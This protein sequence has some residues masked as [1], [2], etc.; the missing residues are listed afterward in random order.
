MAATLR[1]EAGCARY[2]YKIST[3]TATGGVGVGAVDLAKLFAGTRVLPADKAAAGGAGVLYIE[4]SS[5]AAAGGEPRPAD[6]HAL[7]MSSLCYRGYSE[8]VERA[9]K[10]QR[11][12]DAA[13][14]AAA[15]AH[16]TDAS[17]QQPPP[18]KRFD[19]QVT[20]LVRLAGGASANCKVFRNG[21]VQITGLRSIED[22]PLFIEQLISEARAASAV[23]DKD[24]PNMHVSSYAI[25]LIN[26]DVRLGYE[27][28]REVLFDELRVRCPHLYVSYEP[29]IYPG[30]KFLF[31]WNDA[32]AEQDGACTCK[33]DRPN[34]CSGRGSGSG[35][36]QCK[37]MTVAVF[38]SGCMLV[39]GGSEYAHIDAAYAYTLRLLRE[40]EPCVKKA[41]VAA[42]APVVLAPRRAA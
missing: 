33:P 34:V 5:S 29:C 28:K 24:A 37:K 22:G 4:Y 39:T 2:G 7:P 31:Y 13:A 30:V 21:R 12:A 25:A 38:Q 41:P 23:D 32:K 1:G 26:T 20:L 14:A 27:V 6:A 15:A 10:Q 17:A 40:C 35:P 36:G 3:I 16:S 9:L 18:A 42:P 11:A 8:K 19:N